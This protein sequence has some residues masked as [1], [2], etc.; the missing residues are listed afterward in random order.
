MLK[1]SMCVFQVKNTNQIHVPY[2]ISY[3]LCCTNVYNDLPKHFEVLTKKHSLAA[4]TKIS[5]KFQ[6]LQCFYSRELV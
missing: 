2:K 1:E 4:K 5:G 3:K 6:T